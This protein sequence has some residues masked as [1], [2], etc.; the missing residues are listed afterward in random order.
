MNTEFARLLNELMIRQKIGSAEMS[1]TIN[2][3]LVGAPKPTTPAIIDAWRKGPYLPSDWRPIA[4]MAKALEANNGEVEMLLKAAGKGTLDQLAKSNQTSDADRE[5]LRPWLPPDKGDFAALLRKYLGP[6]PKMGSYKVNTATRALFGKAYEVPR[7]NI[8]NWYNTP[9]TPDDWRPI[10]ALAAV[11]RAGATEVE[12][13]LKAANISQTLHELAQDPQT[14][15]A[16]RR[17]L[18]WWL[19][20]SKSIGVTPPIPLVGRTKRLP[21]GS[22]QYLTVILDNL[23]VAYLG[24]NW[25]NHD[26][27]TLKKQ[28]CWDPTADLPDNIEDLRYGLVSVGNTTDLVREQPCVFLAPE[29]LLKSLTVSL[30]LGPQAKRHALSFHLEINALWLQRDKYQEEFIAI[31]NTLDHLH[32]LPSAS[33]CQELELKSCRLFLDGWPVDN[34]SYAVFRLLRTETRGRERASSASPWNRLFAQAE[35]IAQ[36]WHAGERELWESPQ[37]AWEECN[38]LLSEAGKLLRA[39]PFYLPEEAENIY[40]DVLKT[41]KAKIIPAESSKGGMRDY[42]GWVEDDPAFGQLLEAHELDPRLDW[43]ERMSRY[44][45]ALQRTRHLLGRFGGD[46]S[47][48]MRGG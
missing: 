23:Q 48:A 8:D 20:P 10:L 21:L 36:I 18:N 31:L 2:H 17:L 30:M 45:G 1:T 16:D 6:P 29:N 11:F 43:T 35:H 7:S 19:N 26:L 40:Y 12:Q 4:A 25:K 13:M 47:G 5:L 15:F 39:D 42:H 28:I 41:C 9:T 24:Q 34:L 37:D 38:G 46:D 32:P 27:N 44:E 14:T 33:E 3:E 22:S